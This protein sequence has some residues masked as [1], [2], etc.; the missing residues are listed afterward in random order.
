[1]KPNA[2]QRRL[3]REMQKAKVDLDCMFCVREFF[4]LFYLKKKVPQGSRIELTCGND[5]CMNPAHM[6]VVALGH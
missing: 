3:F 5:N 2:E 6:T 1:V 4:Y